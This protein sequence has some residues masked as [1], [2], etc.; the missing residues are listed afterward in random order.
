[1][2]QTSQLPTEHRKGPSSARQLGGYSFVVAALLVTM[3]S[4]AG[5]VVVLIGFI[6]RQRKAEH[7]L[8]DLT[9]FRRGDFAGAVMANLLAA[10]V[11]AGFLIAA[12]GFAF[13][14]AAAGADSPWWFIGGYV[15]LTLSAGG[16][17]SALANTLII[18]T[19][20]P[21]RTGSAASVSETGVQLGGALGIAA[22]GLLSTVFYRQA[23]TEGAPEIT[24]AGDSL[25]EAEA[26]ASQLPA[27]QATALLDAATSAFASSMST[28]AFTIAGLSLAAALLTG[29][30]LRRVPVSVEETSEETD[31][32]ST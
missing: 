9:L 13:I 20:P 14:G 3:G 6:A 2:T 18:S 19:A 12:A 31:A 21:E 4:L 10:R 15:P 22:F 16:M 7:P 11:M 1:M 32:T 23:M 30:L 8:I 17:V 29:A 28:V 25:P 5:G 26:A 27:E 24:G